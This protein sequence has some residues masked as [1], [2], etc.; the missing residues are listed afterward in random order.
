MKA[1]HR[2]SDYSRSSALQAATVSL[3]TLAVIVLVG[4]DVSGQSGA[5]LLRYKL[6]AGDHLIYREV[7][8]SEGKS[9][10]Q[11]FRTRTVFPQRCRR[12]RRSRWCGAGWHPA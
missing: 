4:V 3:G 8:E 9:S 1:T 7:F 6:H 2:R 12:A 5:P 10:D 11:T